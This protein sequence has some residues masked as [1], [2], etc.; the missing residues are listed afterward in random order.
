MPGFLC[1][2]LFTPSNQCSNVN[3]AFSKTIVLLAALQLHAGCSS[4]FPS[5]FLFA[6]VNNLL[7]DNEPC[8]VVDRF[9]D[10]SARVTDNINYSR[11]HA[12]KKKQPMQP[13]DKDSVGRKMV[14][15]CQFSLIE[16]SICQHICCAHLLKSVTQI[17][18]D[19]HTNGVVYGGQ[20]FWK[21]KTKNFI[22]CVLLKNMSFV[23]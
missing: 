3:Q 11:P 22:F 19:I 13:A 6:S 15:C 23:L 12:A 18:T 2:V 16:W 1:F 10:Q 21:T 17:K 5:V 14:A 7:W 4:Q 8:T 9:K 20:V